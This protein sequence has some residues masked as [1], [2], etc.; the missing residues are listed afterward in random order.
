LRAIRVNKFSEQ[1]YSCCNSDTK[2]DGCQ[3]GKHVYDGDDLESNRPIAGFVNTKNSLLNLTQTTN[4]YALDCEMCYTTKGLELTRVSVIDINLKPIYESLVKP[5]YEIIDYNTRW[6]GIT[7]DDL[8]NCKIKLANVQ[9]HL[10]KIFNKDTIL[11]GHSLDSDFKALKLIHKT[12]V[13]TSVVFPHRLGPPMKRA[14]K[15]L[16]SE[17]LQKIIQ[18][19][20]DGHDSKEDACACMELMLWKVQQDIKN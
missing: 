17:F 19:D 15:N 12:V 13:D 11:I 7:L 4:I 5:D 14:L 8:K 9:E 3:V 6:S 20:T 10:L 2:S 18:D 16:T 1:K